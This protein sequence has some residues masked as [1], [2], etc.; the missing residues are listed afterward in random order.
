MLNLNKRTKTKPKPT[1]NSTV[2]TAHVCVCVCVCVCVRI[3]VYNCRTQHSTEQ[4]W[5]FPSYPR[6][7]HH[8]SD[9]VSLTIPSR[10]SVAQLMSEDNRQV[11]NNMVL[12]VPKIMQIYT[13]VLKIL[14]IE[15]SGIAW[16]QK[17][18]PSCWIIA[19][20]RHFVL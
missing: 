7:N 18:K 19:R 13:S 12:N 5:L 2:R 6:D 15:C 9:D 3:I 4:F 8:I 10:Y 16:F 14:A 11:Q 17:R 1:V 20:C